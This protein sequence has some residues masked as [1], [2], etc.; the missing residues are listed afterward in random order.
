[1]AK[2]WPPDLVMF[3][4][5]WQ[6]QHGRPLSGRTCAVRWGWSKTRS[7]VAIERWRTCA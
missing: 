7:F 2:P 6:A 4:L 5:D 3:D 1:L